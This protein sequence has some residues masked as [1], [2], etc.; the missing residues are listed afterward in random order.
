MVE[1]GH[2]EHIVHVHGKS[3]DGGMVGAIVCDLIVG[4]SVETFEPCGEDRNRTPATAAI[5][6]Y[7]ACFVGH[8]SDDPT[9]LATTIVYQCAAAYLL[10]I[11]GVPL[12]PHFIRTSINFADSI[13]RLK[14]SIRV[15]R[16]C[17]RDSK[18]ETQAARAQHLKAPEG[19]E[20]LSI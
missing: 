7:A 13:S 12:S 15:F 19:Y 16:L 2:H 18:A 9:L 6:G 3:S 17:V 10:Y 4:F 20:A 5:T 8:S 14:H 11:C 1:V